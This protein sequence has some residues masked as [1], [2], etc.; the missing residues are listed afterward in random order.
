MCAPF[1]LEWQCAHLEQQ[2][3]VDGVMS[4]DGYCRALGVKTSHFN[5]NFNSKNFQAHDDSVEILSVD[6]NPLLF[7]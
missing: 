4:I 2:N 6:N 5:V 1:E 3:V 7:L